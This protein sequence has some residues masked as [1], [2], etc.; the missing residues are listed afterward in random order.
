LYAGRIIGHNGVL[1]AEACTLGHNRFAGHSQKF[2]RYAERTLRRARIA[3]EDQVR[4]LWTV[5][6][7]QLAALGAM[8]ECLGMSYGTTARCA[9]SLVALEKAFL[10]VSA[11]GYASLHQLLQTP[12]ASSL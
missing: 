1:L 2:E 11:A 6:V 9:V 3:C 5:P 7:I 4:N 10:A 12:Q 8:G